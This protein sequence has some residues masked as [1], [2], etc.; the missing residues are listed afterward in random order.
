MMK[1]LVIGDSLVKSETL[2][3]AAYE[4]QFDEPIEVV[5]LEHLS[6][7]TKEEFQEYI[8]E[9]ETNGPNN[10][11]LP[12][13]VL[14]EIKDADI[15]LVHIAPISEKMLS[16]AKKL[17]FI[18]TC[19][20]G[21]EHIDM[22]KANE[23]E[24][25][26]MHVIRNAEPV[27]DFTVGLILAETRNIARSHEAIRQGKWL[28]TFP[29]DKYKTV[30]SN[31]KIGL[32]GLG[33]IGKL[34]AKRLIALNVDIVVHDPYIQGEEATVD[35]KGHVVKLVSLEDLFEKSDVISLHARLTEENK[36]MVNNEL[37]SKMKPS[38]YMINTGRAGLIEKKALVNALRNNQ[39]AGAALDVIWEEPI[40]ED[41]ELL[42]LD[43]LTITSHIA[44]DTIDAIPLSPYLLR[45]EINKYL[46]E[47]N[48]DMIVNNFGK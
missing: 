9:I 45:D 12:E 14:E 44:G 5:R 1:V 6:D 11:E 17:K 46:T 21:L 26:V 3:K 13:N 35:E 28:K 48:T 23:K 40:N 33:H 43:N 27:A 31:L 8:L 19:R 4:L 10:I 2:E 20:G 47:G 7:K 39:I 18:G 42:E 36:N 30:L 25:P 15:L 24:I 41:D 34:V 16:V 38:S 37:I 29:N 22:E 32:V